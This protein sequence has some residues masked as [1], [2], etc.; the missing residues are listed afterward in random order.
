MLRN[1]TEEIVI[2]PR[3]SS[4]AKAALTVAGAVVVI[5]ITGTAYWL[6]ER[7]NDNLAAV[8]QVKQELA[9]ERRRNQRLQESL[10][11][12]ERQLRIDKTAY[13][14]LSTA[15]AASSKQMA[16]LE[17]ELKFYRSII[18]PTN[19]ERGVK[20]QDFTIT[21][22]DEARQYR[23]KLVLIQALKHDQV[24]RGT[25]TIAIKGM[26]NGDEKVLTTPAENET[27]L[28]VKFKYFQNVEGVISL[29]S[30]FRPSEVTITLVTGEKKPKTTTRNYPW[31]T[32]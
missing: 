13:S 32:A 6:G 10:A 29:P 24:V 7:T 30:D 12:V 25:V 14:E 16:E 22:A 20:I 3:L 18:A 5:G 2:R 26:H 28:A 15:L 23:Y 11:Q 8:V 27:P 4:P 9:T 1:N 31:P 17:N 19:N 21:P